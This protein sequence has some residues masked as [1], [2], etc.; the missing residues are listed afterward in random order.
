[1]HGEAN[2]GES[3][4]HFSAIVKAETTDEFVANAAA[5]EDFFE[6]TGLEVG[7][8]FDGAGLVRIVIENFLEFSGDKFSFGLCVTG[9]EVAK[10][11]ASG[12]AIGR[13]VTRSF[14]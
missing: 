8:V 1:M 14:W 2:I 12:C 9:F 6:G 3:V 4:F 7:A 13:V 10:I 11:F 5:A